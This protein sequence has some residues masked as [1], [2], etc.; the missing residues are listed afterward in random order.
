MGFACG[1]FCDALVPNIARR[2]AFLAGYEFAGLADALLVCSGFTLGGASIATLVGTVSASACF[3]KIGKAVGSLGFV[4]GLA[5]LLAGVVFI[6]FGSLQRSDVFVHEHY[7]AGMASRVER[8][9]ISDAVIAWLGKERLAGRLGSDAIAI[10]LGDLPPELQNLFRGNPPEVTRARVASDGGGAS[11][12]LVWGG[13]MSSWGVVFS[14]G[15][16]NADGARVG[17]E[18]LVNSHAL[19]F[20]N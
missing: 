14:S 2:F 18:R 6:A 17:R 20:A 12:Q 1:L 16:L 3:W 4:F 7:V 13:G 8:G 10:P 15:I 11:L 9:K 19:V 5:S